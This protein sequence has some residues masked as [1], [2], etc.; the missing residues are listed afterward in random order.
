MNHYQ[1]ARKMNEIWQRPQTNL[2]PSCE[3][4][5]YTIR[6]DSLLKGVSVRPFCH[7]TLNFQVTF[8]VRLFAFQVSISSMSW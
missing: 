7:M 5:L 4:A 2:S 8:V 1:P 6:R 3:M